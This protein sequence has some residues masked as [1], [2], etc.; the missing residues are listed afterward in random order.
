MTLCLFPAGLNFVSCKSYIV[1]KNIRENVN[2]RLR[3]VS[4]R[5]GAM[6]YSLKRLCRGYS[7]LRIER[8]SKGRRKNGD[9]AMGCPTLGVWGGRLLHLRCQIPSNCKHREGEDDRNDTMRL[10]YDILW[11]KEC[12]S[13]SNNINTHANE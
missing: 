8:E 12:K 13:L 11:L 5:E 4:W 3:D 9:E 10:V 2:C 7:A 1:P 6:F